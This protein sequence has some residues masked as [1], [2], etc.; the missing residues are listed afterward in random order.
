MKNKLL[1]LIFLTFGVL[2]SLHA[3]KPWVELPPFFK[4]A[5]VVAGV[6][7]DGVNVLFIPVE[8]HGEMWIQKIYPLPLE[9]PKT[10]TTDW[11]KHVFTGEV[12]F[13]KS[14]TIQLK[15]KE[16]HLV[17]VFI[18]LD[19]RIDHATT[20]KGG[21]HKSEFYQHF[22]FA[23]RLERARKLHLGSRSNYVNTRASF[24]SFPSGRRLVEATYGGKKFSETFLIP[25]GVKAKLAY[26]KYLIFV[27]SKRYLLPW[28]DYVEYDF[29]VFNIKHKAGSFYLEAVGYKPNEFAPIVFRVSSFRSFF[30][31]IKA[32]KA[33][34]TAH[35]NVLVRVVDKN[36][37]S[38]LIS[39]LG[40][41]GEEQVY[42]KSSD[43]SKI[44]Y[45]DV[46][47]NKF[48]FE[49]GW[50]VSTNLQYWLKTPDGAKCLVKE[51][52]PSG[53]QIAVWLL[54]KKGSH[55]FEIR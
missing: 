2:S 16:G 24:K 15:T 52:T 3:T 33:Y 7:E 44:I 48:T 20:N 8:V 17:E 18:R 6:E 37:I 46:V 39:G 21:F 42:F 10:D 1:A 54:F 40:Y 43:D 53:T 13:S 55:L 12:N 49:F 5:G 32:Q 11:K 4:K 27:D 19:G 34:E 47:N 38:T 28:F 26:N 14:E 36:N 41:T 31:R 45:Y 23:K 50:S 22:G 29:V 25:S 51:L 30:A 35:Q 9:I